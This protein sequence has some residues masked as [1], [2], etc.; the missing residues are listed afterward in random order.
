[1]T[2]SW[3]ERVLRALAEWPAA[4]LVLAEIVVLSL[5]VVYR[6]VLQTPLTWSDELAS[7]LFLWLAMLG[8]VVAL[9][10][11]E[12]MRLT[13][14]VARLSEGKRRK[15]ESLVACLTVL[16]CAA[17]LWPAIEHMNEQWVI[18]TPALEIPD[19]LRVAAVVVGLGL[20]L[21]QSLLQ[22]SRAARGA[23]LTWALGCLLVLGAALHGAS[24]FLMNFGHGNLLLFFVLMVG[25]CVV[26]GLPIAFAFGLC[27]LAYLQFSTSTPLTIVVSR[28]DEGMSH[29]ILLSV[30]LFVFLGAFIAVTGLAKAMVQFLASLLGHFRGGL[31]YV[32]LAAMYLVSGISGSKA[33]DMAAVAPALFPEMKQRGADPGRL[34]ALLA[35]SGA[36]SETI[37]P[38][39][40]LITIGAVTGVSIAALFVGGLMPALVGMLAL[41]VV[42][43]WQARGE[44]TVLVARTPLP[45]VMR[46]FWLALPALALP[47]VIRSAVV[48]GVATA[49]EVSTIG[50]LYT[51]I[52]GTLVYRQLDWRRIYPM[53]VETASL[54]GAILLIIGCATAMAWALTQSGFSRD[55]VALMTQVPG[56]AMGFMV[57][58]LVVFVILGSMLEGIPAIVLFGPLLFPVARA[59]GIH[60]V[61]YAMVVVF[62]MGLGLFAPPVGV[63][64]YAACAIGKVEADLALHKIW[65]YLGALMVAL[66]VIAFVP[67]VSIGFL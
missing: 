24:P 35:A 18:L 5:G 14:F 49:T 27:T 32:L 34:V 64:F 59:L 23:D 11:G 28:I 12:H 58:S 10:H 30:P 20:M 66:L 40:V 53:L 47:F 39:L 36:M 22:L 37:P 56:G 29:L 62:A 65:P 48:E 46:C 17:L 45:E 55:L 21:M 50:I 42:V 2:M 25:V 1:M 38:S 43:Y 3:P 6:Y 63:G 4:L 31:Q 67:W 15:V 13:V 19:A 33:A 54:S 9:Q 44:N 8:A 52:V 26:M 41:C 7:I 16:F 57:V 61:H 51:L 60:E